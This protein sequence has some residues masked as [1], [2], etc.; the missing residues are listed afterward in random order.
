MVPSMTQPPV[1]PCM[2]L[3][4]VIKDEEGALALKCSNVPEGLIYPEQVSSGM[5][6][7]PGA[8]NSVR[9]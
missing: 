4:Q 2:L 5:Q 1:N 6:L 7:S 9:S 3:L 8:H